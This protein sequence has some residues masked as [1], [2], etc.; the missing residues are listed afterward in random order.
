MWIE[1]LKLKFSEANTNVLQDFSEAEF[2][3]SVPYFWL[4]IWWKLFFVCCYRKK[5]MLCMLPFAMFFIPMNAHCL[6]TKNILVF[7]IVDAE[8]W[9]ILSQYIFWKKN[10]IFL[11]VDCHIRNHYLT[12]FVYQ[13][14]Y[15]HL[16]V[17]C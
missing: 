11:N 15:S 14:F 16:E 17:N 10:V 6:K 3:A 2:I 8:L 9:Y 7:P 13:Y 12:T 4:C 1:C 5:Y